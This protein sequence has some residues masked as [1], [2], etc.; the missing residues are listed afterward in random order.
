MTF[1]KFLGLLLA[2]LAGAV[3]LVWLFVSLA[4]LVHAL[5]QGNG[6]AARTYAIF[7]AVGLVVC[8]LAGWTA[9]RVARARSERQ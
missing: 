5:S 9:H 6:A 7:A 2:M 1:A 4:A 8:V 3:V